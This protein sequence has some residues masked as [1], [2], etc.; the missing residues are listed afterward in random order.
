MIF[1]DKIFVKV[2]IKCV[3][4]CGS[5]FYGNDLFGSN[6]FYGYYFVINLRLDRSIFDGLYITGR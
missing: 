1:I 5:G 6:I 4:I 3:I 2:K